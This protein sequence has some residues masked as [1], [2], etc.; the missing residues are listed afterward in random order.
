MKVFYVFMGLIQALILRIFPFLGYEGVINTQINIYK[1]IKRVAP[2]DISEN[3][4]LN[5]LI[6]SRVRSLPRISSQ[7]SEIAYYLPILENSE[8]TLEDVVWSI[9]EYEYF[10]SSEGKT[11]NKLQRMGIPRDEIPMEIESLKEKPRMY[12]RRKIDK[13]IKNA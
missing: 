10:L 9:V 5:Y 4:I 6:D 2:P 3:E 13:E 11:I 7:E 8:K 1:R 12:L